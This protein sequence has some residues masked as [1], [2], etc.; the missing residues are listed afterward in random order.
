MEQLPN[1]GSSRFAR[2]RANACLRFK[3]SVA[4]PSSPQTLA[5]FATAPTMRASRA[6]PQ[7]PSKLSWTS[8]S[9]PASRSWRS[10]SRMPRRPEVC[11]LSAPSCRPTIAGTGAAAA[12]AGQGVGADSTT[13]RGGAAVQERRRS[14]KA[15]AANA[16]QA[17]AKTRLVKEKQSARDE[18]VVPCGCSARSKLRSCS[19]CRPMTGLG[20][21]G[22]PMQRWS[23]R[24][25][26]R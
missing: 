13:D 17:Q 21:L 11:C 19:N 24:R 15:M 2:L 8:P 22:A 1:L 5:N 10:T 16:E 26:A 14:A 23:G 25:G 9:L 6:P 7:A 4:D 18:N 20:T 12:A 3:A